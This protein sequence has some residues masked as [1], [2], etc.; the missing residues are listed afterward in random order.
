MHPKCFDYCLTEEEARKFKRDGYFI[1]P[2]ALPPDMVSDLV[3]AVD[4]VDKEERARMGK[5]A[6]ARINHYDFIGKDDHFLPLLDLVQN[7]SQSVGHPG[8]AH[9]TL[10]HPHDRDPPCRT[11]QNTRERRTWPRFPSRQWPHQSRL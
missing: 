2:D 3:V 8:L 5:S 1:V 9:P 11:A 7:I 10:P 4:R 6:I